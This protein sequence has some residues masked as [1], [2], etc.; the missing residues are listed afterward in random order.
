MPWFNYPHSGAR[1]LIAIALVFVG[2][3]LLAAAEVEWTFLSSKHGDLPIPGKTTRQVAAV[4]ADL[5][6]NGVNDFVLA[7]RDSPSTLVWYRRSD[8]G[9]TRYEIEKAMLPVNAGGGVFDID[10]D[11]D[12]DLVFGGTGRIWWWENPEPEFEQNK[13]WVRRTIKIAEP[14]SYGELTFGDFK[15][16]GRPQVVFWDAASK[17]LFLAEI[18]ARPKQSEDWPATE[19]FSKHGGEERAGRPL[20]P[21]SGGAGPQGDGDTDGLGAFDIDADGKLDLVAG[22]HWLKYRIANRWSAIRIGKSGGRIAVGRF[23]PGRYPQVIIA[24]ANRTGRLMLYESKGHPA[25]SSSWSGQELLPQL[26]HGHSL[27]VG[28]INADGRLD[29]FCAEMA[30]WDLDR[31][32]ADNPEATAWI[33]Y[34]NGTGDF[35]K[36]VLMTGH[37]WHEGRLSDLDGDGDLDLMNKPYAWQIP[38]V[39]VWLNLR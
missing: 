26:V 10:G 34:G 31:P 2:G 37:G 12:L 18:P 30:K 9:W 35:Q 7:L 24:P 33:L 1:V 23:K 39:D 5:D 20:P 25:F 22:N 21:A 36:T 32:T 14:A 15:S 29:I 4:A 19:I 13:S 38:R 27:Q 28:D 11:A 17:G 6:N 16:M 8:I 3:R